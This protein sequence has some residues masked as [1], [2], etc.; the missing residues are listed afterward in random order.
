MNPDAVPI[1]SYILKVASRCNLNCSYCYMYNKGDDSY[2]GQPPVMSRETIRH[3]LAKVRTHCIEQ[4]VGEVTFSFH[5][6]EP[7]LAGPEFFRHFVADAASILGESVTVTYLLETNGTLLTTQWL[8]LF[9]ELGIGFGI[10]LD[11]PPAIHDRSRVNHAGLGSYREVRR[12]IDL[13]VANP[14]YQAVFGGV[15][16]VVDLSS[17]PLEVYHHLRQ[18]GIAQCDFLL[19]DGTWNHPP[20]GV[21]LEATSTPYADWLISIFDPWFDSQDTSF[22]IRLFDSIIRL[23]F[24][25]HAGNDSLGGGQNGLLVIE[26]DG[27]I[28]PVDVLKICG[29]SFTK[30]GLNVADDQISDAYAVDLVQLYVQGS[31]AAC[32]TCRNCPV[33]SVCGAGYLPHRYSPLNGF[34]NPSVYCRDLMKLITHVRDRVLTAMPATTRRKLGLEPLGYE[35]A[36]AILGAH[37]ASTA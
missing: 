28:E 4:A 34:D 20:K 13:V 36:L 12:A 37:T 33:F 25:T 16:S 27:E 17:D 26:T 21:E 9:C 29:P 10:S 30:T 31:A 19:P 1:N 5:G 24:D 22:S 3:L 32:R 14:R 18:I 2:T 35:Q 23:L 8:D 6:G 7:L 11:G 15:L